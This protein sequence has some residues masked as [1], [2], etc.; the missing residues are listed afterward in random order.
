MNN[1]E[2]WQKEAAHYRRLYRIMLGL[3]LPLG[4]A[5]GVL[6]GSLVCYAAH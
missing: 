6:V 4:A 5:T 1:T 3:W 2:Y